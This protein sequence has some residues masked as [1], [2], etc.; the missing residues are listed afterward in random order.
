MYPLACP[1]TPIHADASCDPHS[2]L[3]NEE[4]SV[5][6]LPPPHSTLAP[7]H[8]SA[9]LTHKHTHKALLNICTHLVVLMQ[10]M[11][12][13]SSILFSSSQS[14]SHPITSCHT[15]HS[16]ETA[17]VSPTGSS[18]RGRDQQE[19]SARCAA[20]V[21]FTRSTTLSDAH[22][23]SSHPLSRSL[24]RR[25]PPPSTHTLQHHHTSCTLVH[26]QP[27]PLPSS[28]KPDCPPLQGS[29]RRWQQRASS[30]SAQIS[31]RECCVL[32]QGYTQSALQQWSSLPLLLM[33][34]PHLLPIPPSLQA[35]PDF[36]PQH[37]VNIH[38]HR[39][40]P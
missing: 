22:Y 15:L 14:L 37:N 16:Q 36:P 10:C 6:R 23:N 3:H 13:R 8:S 1:C 31:C 39:A 11:S 26:A 30:G 5:S 4:W 34:P 19:G 24:A 9:H 29:H 38:E 12:V 21:V 20:Q 35:E 32:P 7:S 25:Y 28:P 40:Y 27:E 17:S 2:L 18:H 33:P